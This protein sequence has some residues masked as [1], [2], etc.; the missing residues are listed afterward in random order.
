MK[1]PDYAS[2]V[3][4]EPCG[5]AFYDGYSLY[6]TSGGL[7]TEHCGHWLT[8]S[9]VVS[10]YLYDQLVWRA[11][12]T[13][14]VT[15]WWSVVIGQPTSPPDVDVRRPCTLPLPRQPR[16]VANECQS[17]IQ[18]PR[19]PVLGGKLLDPLNAWSSVSLLSGLPQPIFRRTHSPNRLVWSEGWR[20]PGAQS[21]FIKWTGRTLAMTMSWWQ[22]H[23]H[24]HSYYYY[25]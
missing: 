9:H 15:Y 16:F 21:A 14:M 11:S 7:K 23:K 19:S 17:F 25:Y 6:M 3:N 5:T 12:G 2:V 10:P 24:C 22:H 20:P 13:T 8:T 1:T 18:T 4:L